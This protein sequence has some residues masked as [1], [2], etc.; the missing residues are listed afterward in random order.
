MDNILSLNFETGAPF[1]TSPYG[2]TVAANGASFASGRVRLNGPGTFLVT[3]DAPE[4][5][6]GSQDF[7]FAMLVKLAQTTSP[8]ANSGLLAQYNAA[9]GDDIFELV[10]NTTHGLRLVVRKAGATVLDLAQVSS[11]IPQN[12]DCLVEIER[13]GT[14][15]KLKRNGVVVKSG[16]FA[17][18]M[19]NPNSPLY[20]GYAFYSVGQSIGFNG[21][22]D[23]IVMNVGTAP[24]VPPPPPTALFAEGGR[25]F[26]AREA[27]LG[28]NRTGQRG[29]FIF[30]NTVSPETY[31]DLPMAQYPAPNLYSPMSWHELDVV[32]AGLPADTL[33]V[34]IGG[35]IGCTNPVAATGDLHIHLRSLHGPNDNYIFQTLANG[36]EGERSMQNTWVAVKDGKFG[37]AWWCN[38]A[39]P[40]AYPNGPAFFMNLN[41]TAYLVP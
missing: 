5:D 28:V 21:W 38:G 18:S 15:I 10:H 27:P 2:R 7:R 31:A 30:I 24:P 22:L 13:V 14:T 36:H 11:P 6:L 26:V 39:I 12:T 9:D 23:D 37:F 17:Q 34:N 20:L 35:I 8:P 3:Q 33:A 29:T 40:S 1:D 4:F 32:A 19:P 41:L 25:V 16:M